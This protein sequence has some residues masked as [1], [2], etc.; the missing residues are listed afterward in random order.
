MTI[1]SNIKKLRRQRDITQE[2]LA[3]YLNISVSA[4]SQWECGKTTPD[5]S[6]LAPLANVLDVSADMLLG[7]DVTN[8][9][10]QI[11]DI[12]ISSENIRHTDCDNAILILRNGLKEFPNSYDLMERLMSCVFSKTNEGVLA[13]TLAKDE[14]A[15]LTNE[16]IKLGEKILAE[17]TDDKIRL[18][19]LNTLC[20]TYASPEAGMID[21]AIEL[22][23]NLP[24]TCITRETLLAQLYTGEKQ[25]KQLRQN[26]LW[27]FGQL[28][29]DAN[30]LGAKH[31]ADNENT[32]AYNP[33][34][35][36]E[37][38]LFNKKIVALIDTMIED[39]NYGFF[40]FFIAGSCNGLAR[41]YAKLRDYDNVLMYL[42]R[43]ADI[44]IKVHTEYSNINMNMP[45]TFKY[46]SMLFKGTIN[47]YGFY[48]IDGFCERQLEY[49]KHIAFD[50]IRGTEAFAEIEERLKAYVG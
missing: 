25:F 31:Y 28:I 4:I 50:A 24:H 1:D 29:M 9:E 16:L 42:N 27:H 43:A 22:A 40:S 32:I 30:E 45:S 5:I 34:K 49:M 17:C 35:V 47:M 44:A 13:N 23:E 12:M 48:P 37:S 26:L 41:N 3:E 20:Y 38:I 46:T 14:A 39:G 21:K 7:I 10:K 19:A 11:Q 2:Q 18:Q 15:A 6:L 36:E 33:R 8:K